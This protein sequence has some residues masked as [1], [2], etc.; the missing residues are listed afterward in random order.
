MAEAANL[1]GTWTGSGSTSELA[2]LSD[3][4]NLDDYSAGSSPCYYQ[5]SADDSYVYQVDQV[6]VFINNLLD[7][8]PYDSYLKLQGSD[9]AQTSWTDI[10]TF[11]G[12]IHEGWNTILPD[13]GQPPFSYHTFRFYGE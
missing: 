2:K 12:D 4:N 6:K 10:Y 8:T 5:I 7:I 9:S 11:D 13:E 1:S 3:G